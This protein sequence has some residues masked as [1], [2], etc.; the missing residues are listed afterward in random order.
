MRQRALFN[1]TPEPP[2]IPVPK[3]DWLAMIGGVI[4]LTRR[5][6]RVEIRAGVPR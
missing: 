1:E 4:S 5:L 2:A 3:F 6:D